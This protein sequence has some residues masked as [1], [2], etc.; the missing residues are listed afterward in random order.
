[1]KTDSMYPLIKPGDI[2]CYKTANN[3]NL[4]HWGEMYIIYIFIDGEEYLTIK[5]IE[6]SDFDDEYVRLTGYNQIYQP[7]DIPLK[8]IQWKALIK[9]HVSYN[10]IM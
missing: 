9:A 10:S 2:V 5:K 6:K 1:M 4:I 7:K 3:T 8:N